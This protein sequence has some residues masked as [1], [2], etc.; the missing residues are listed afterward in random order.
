MS[1]VPGLVV[2]DL[3]GTL[4]RGPTVCE[5]FASAIGRL[6]QMRKFETYVT[7]TDITRAREEMARWYSGA[8]RDTL[9]QALGS[10]QWAP[11]AAEGVALLK[12][13]GVRVAIASITW[14][15]AVKR[16][17][18]KLNVDDSIGTG[19]SDRGEITHVWPED[20]PAWVDALAKR[21]QLDSTRVAAVGDSQ[22]DRGMLTAAGL[23]Y[24]VGPRELPGTTFLHRP[25][26]D[27]ATLAEE[28]LAQ[29]SLTPVNR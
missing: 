17:A 20:K 5:L 18:E 12:A 15:F 2:F 21:L 7:K 29:W 19:L 24:F 14:D 10:A 6:E 23:P 9:M 26:A 8:S 1:R 27:I 22:G 3:D 11:R 16:F 25:S 13:A 28:I 4:L